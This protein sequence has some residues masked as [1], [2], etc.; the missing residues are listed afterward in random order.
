MTDDSLTHG[1]T[2]EDQILISAFR[3]SLGRQTYIVPDCCRWIQERWLVL[4]P[5][6]R[7]IIFNELDDAVQR[8]ERWRMR[9]GNDGQE[10]MYLGGLIDVPIWKG[11]HAWIKSEYQ[12]RRQSLYVSRKRT[13]RDFA[14]DHFRGQKVLIWSGE[15]GA[16]WGPNNCGYYDRDRAGAY[17]FEEAYA[18]T[19]HCGPEKRI[20]YEL[21]P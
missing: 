8:D 20:A 16:Y 5:A 10:P 4:H 1:L 3:Y 13:E 18:V 12:Q 7:A 14:F 15:H 19:Q 6:A 21:V 17:T 11:L 9:P 2:D